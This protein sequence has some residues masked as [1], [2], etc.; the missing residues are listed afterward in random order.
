MN[1][2]WTEAAAAHV[3]SIRNYI[4]CDS[5]RNAERFAERILQK[6]DS[7]GTLPEAGAIVPEYKSPKIREVFEGSYRIIYRIYSDRVDILAVIHGARRLP[8][9]QGA[10]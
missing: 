2:A 10:D 8:R 7:V 3:E 4:A 1:V 6:G 5:R 9:I